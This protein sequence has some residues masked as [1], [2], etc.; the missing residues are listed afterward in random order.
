MDNY[1]VFINDVLTLEQFTDQEN[2]SSL[3]NQ[4]KEPNKEGKKK[5]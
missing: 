2:L 1:V 5:K 4:P 3:I